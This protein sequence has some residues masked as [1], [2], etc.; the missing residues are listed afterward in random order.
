MATTTTTQTTTSAG[1]PRVAGGRYRSNY[2]GSEYRVE[3]ISV[4]ANG[5]L[6]SITVTDDH[7]TRTHCTAWD[8]RDDILFDPRTQRPA[9]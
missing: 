7:G 1:D 9:P 6:E 3:A 8:S 4:T 5:H 2:W